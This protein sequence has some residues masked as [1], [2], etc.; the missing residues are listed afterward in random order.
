MGFI[1][2]CR[3]HLELCF[4]FLWTCL[5][6]LSFYG[7]FF[8]FL[9]TCF[10]FF[11]PKVGAVSI[12]VYIHAGGRIPYRFILLIPQRKRNWWSAIPMISLDS[13]DK[14]W[15]WQFLFTVFL[16]NSSTVCEE[17]VFSADQWGK[18]VFGIMKREDASYLPNQS[19]CKISKKKN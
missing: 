13:T 4:F 17:D 2:F 14:F 15:R 1:W 8:F 18:A 3:S 7:L 12:W 16:N 5:L 9:W 11:L 19:N 10:F 6:N